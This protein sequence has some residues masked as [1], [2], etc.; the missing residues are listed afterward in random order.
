[1]TMLVTEAIKCRYHI[2]SVLF[3]D[4]AWQYRWHIKSSF[5]KPL[6]KYDGEMVYAKASQYKVTQLASCKL[7][8]LSANNVHEC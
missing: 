7:V 3:N 6:R 4:A 2:Y 5:I 8:Y 1:M